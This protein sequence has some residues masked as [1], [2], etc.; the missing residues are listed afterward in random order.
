MR[1]TD[2]ADAV[3]GADLTAALAYVTPAGGVVVTAVAPV[4][5]R[6][7]EAGWIAFST[8]LGFGRKLDRIRR[9]PRV[10]LAFHSR[11]YAVAE[12]GTTPD[13]AFVLVQGKAEIIA[14]PS[15]EDRA[16]LTAHSARM[17]GPAKH[18][19][20]F[21][22]RWLREYYRVR[23]PVRIAVERV[24]RWPDPRCAGPHD[25]LGLPWPDGPA[26][27]QA[28]PTGGAAPRVDAARA[29]RRGAAHTHHLL[30]YRG[31]DGYPVV[32]PVHIGTA[33]A[34]GIRLTS[35]P[36]LLPPGGRRAG[37]LVHSYR[38]ALVG[39]ST[40]YHTGW[41]DTDEQGEA[42][43]APHTSGGFVAPPNRTLMLFFNGLMA[44]RGVRAFREP[45]TGRS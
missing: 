28:P 13:D 24:V 6:D 45:S 38:P 2:E 32:V 23:V 31:S 9:D 36:G 34:D 11:Q 16:M 43:Y 10:A 41:L 5:M 29:A 27:P 19:R 44:K 21:W 26:P 37:L 35:T 14:D 8:S 20:L 22:D 15:D 18:G 40:R 33:G 7:R 30:G 12:P 4:G 25:V 17:L 1:W 42:R 39:L 3:F